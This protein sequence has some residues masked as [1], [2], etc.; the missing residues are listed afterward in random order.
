[1]NNYAIYSCEGFAREVLPSVRKQVLTSDADPAEDF[2]VCVDDNPDQVG[3]IIHG[4]NVISFE[5]L[6]NDKDRLINVCIA[7]PW[8]RRNVVE[9]C[10]E[11]GFGFFSI[12]DDSHTRFDNVDVGEGAVFC[13]YS[14]VTGDAQIGD[15]FHCNIYSYI[16]H[17]CRIGDFVTFAPRVSCNG[18]VQIDDHAYVGTGA[19]LKQGTQDK[20]LRVGRGAVVGMGS[21]ITKD[22]PDGAVVVGN[23]ARVIRTLELEA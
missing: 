11:A 21:V 5:E 7:D 23:P 22:V 17:D 19:V 13:A 4:C 20:P 1:M 3:E 12:A 15:H 16:A 8:I 2:I 6:S 14:M 18:R 10:R 9:K